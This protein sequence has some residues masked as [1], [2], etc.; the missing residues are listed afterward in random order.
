LQARDGRT[1]SRGNNRQVPGIEPALDL[2]NPY[3][4]I[5]QNLSRRCLTAIDDLPLLIMSEFDEQPGLRL[6]F[7]QTTR[8]WDLSAED[9]RDVLAYLVGSGL[10]R[11]ASDG[12]YCRAGRSA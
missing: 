8:L 3:E 12:Q 4:V 5:M 6:T 10:L 1:R 11:R 9:C 2:E 7:G